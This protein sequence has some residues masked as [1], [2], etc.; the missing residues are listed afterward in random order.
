[1]EILPYIWAY[2][3]QNCEN[4]TFFPMK[5]GFRAVYMIRFAVLY[6]I[7]SI[8]YSYAQKGCFV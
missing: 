7:H 4:L 6:C 1:M 2:A 5:G 3:A 8:V